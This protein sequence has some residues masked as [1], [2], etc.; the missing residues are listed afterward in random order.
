MR[1]ATIPGRGLYARHLGHPEG[2]DSVHRTTVG[3]PGAARPRASFDRRWVAECAAD[4]DVVHVLGLPS[5]AD[6]AEVAATADAVRATGTPLV[7]TGYHLSDPTGTDAAGH[8][9]RMDALVPRA[10]AV[11]T[12]TDSAAEE[13]RR[14]WDVEALVLPHPHA[15]DF[16]RMR[17]PRPQFRGDRLLVG[18]HLAALRLPVDPVLFVDA[19]TRAV[20]G[21]DTAM[22]VVHLHETVVDSGSNAYA[23]EQVREIEALV[24][25]VGGAVR[26]HRPFTEPRLWDHL[27]SLDVSVVPGLYGS[28]SVWPEACTDLGTT[29]LLPAGTHAAQQRPCLTYEGASGADGDVDAL[30]DSLGKALWTAREQ[31]NV[32]RSDP[33]QRWAERVRGAESLRGVYERLLGWDRW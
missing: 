26:V 18:L 3:P 17:Q 20:H 15:V 31:G 5:T 32:W 22:L 19:L 8:D 30:A 33:E 21:V 14:R 2:V 10:D 27:F 9:A 13:M 11:V 7:V 28:H 29:P 4:V 1:V 25:G 23:P 16:V 12:L 24:A 6:P